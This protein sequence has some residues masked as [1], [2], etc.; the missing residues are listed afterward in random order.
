MNTV[1]QEAPSTVS[2]MAASVAASTKPVSNFSSTVI[3]FKASDPTKVF[4]TLKDGTHPTVLVRGCLCPIGGNWI[5]PNAAMHKSPSDTVISEF[6]EETS[7]DK[8]FRSGEEL[9]LLG[10]ADSIAT[11]QPTEGSGAEPT[12]EDRMDLKVVIGAVVNSIMPMAL[13]ENTVSKEALDAA[14][15]ANKKDGFTVANSYFTAGLDD[16]TW[17]KLERLQKKFGNLSNE[18]VSV[19]TSLDEIINTGTKCAFGHDSGLKFFFEEKGYSVYGFPAILGVTG[20][21]KGLVMD[22]YERMLEV[23]AP[24][25]R[26]T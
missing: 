2:T 11:F 22:S 4:L 10:L 3:V 17:A 5:G 1:V 26:P 25:K 16:E 20:E 9:A 12:S 23:Y 14:D 7:F 18:S 21:C 19:I 24:A 13:F 6:V 8:P 15:L